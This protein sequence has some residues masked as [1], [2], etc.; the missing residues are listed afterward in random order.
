MGTLNE[1]KTLYFQRNF[2]SFHPEIYQNCVKNEWF[3]QFYTGQPNE[4]FLSF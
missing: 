2:G 3:L 4:D 1:P